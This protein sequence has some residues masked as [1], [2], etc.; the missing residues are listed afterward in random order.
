RVAAA[1][2]ALADYASEGCCYSFRDW[3]DDV[4]AVAVPYREPRERRWL[5][6]SCS[7]PASSMGEEVFR[8]RIGPKLRALAQRLGEPG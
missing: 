8:R 6:L 3:H 5:I 1:A 2:R 7:G 4:N